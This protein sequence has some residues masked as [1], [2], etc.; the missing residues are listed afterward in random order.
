MRRKMFGRKL[1]KASRVIHIDACAQTRVARY[2]VMTLMGGRAPSRLPCV[3]TEN[4]G[5]AVQLI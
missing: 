5:S 4:L 2:V 3:K 1:I